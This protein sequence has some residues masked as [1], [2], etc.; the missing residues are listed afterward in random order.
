MAEATSSRTG[1]V[2]RKTNETAVSVSVNIDGTGTSKIATGVGFFDHML[3]QL[4]RHSLIDMEIK[5]DGDLHV[6]DHHT[7]EDT[8]IA[9]GQAIA[10][11][12]GDRRGITRYAS[13]DLA[14]DETMTRAAVD[15]SGRPFLVWNVAFTSPKIGT[16]DTELVREFFQALAQNAG[17]TL[18]IQNI[19]GANN[20]HIAETCFKSVA[21]VLRTATEI[22][23]RQAGRVPS[24]K[25]TLA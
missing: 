24:T 20:H 9:I 18:H 10:K 19:Y 2:S 7:V 17:I 22:D 16:F 13:L 6:D 8:G 21:R 23:P 15:V 14:M 12:L 1:Q 4:S 5:T 25:G 11:A 3:D